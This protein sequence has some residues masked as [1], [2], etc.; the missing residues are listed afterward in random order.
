VT[1]R[2]S[3]MSLRRR[4]AQRDQGSLEVD[5][6]KLGVILHYRMS[7]RFSNWL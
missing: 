7:I 6:P 2:M 4:Q 5:K 1:T 3:F